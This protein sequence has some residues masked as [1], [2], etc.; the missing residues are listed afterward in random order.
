MKQTVIATTLLGLLGTPTA[1]AQSAKGSSVGT[2]INGAIPEAPIGHRQPRASDVPNEKNLSNDAVSK[3]DAML[4]KKI[5]SI[6]R[7]C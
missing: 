4:D 3:E 5:K 6:C 1:I 7:G 2:T